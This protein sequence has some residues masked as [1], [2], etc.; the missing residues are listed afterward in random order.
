MKLL[1][2][3]HITVLSKQMQLQMPCFIGLR[4]R[5]LGLCISKPCF[6]FSKPY[7]YISKPCFHVFEPYF[8]GSEL[9]YYVFE[10]YLSSLILILLSFMLL[11]LHFSEPHSPGSTILSLILSA[12]YT[13]L[14]LSSL[15]QIFVFRILVLS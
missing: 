12:P 6:Q 1:M 14:I 11:K 3:C 7:F 5:F 15:H 2:L 4:K 10:L 9:C 8:H 13:L